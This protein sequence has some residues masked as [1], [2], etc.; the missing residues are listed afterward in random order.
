[1]FG[2]QNILR[3]ST[4]ADRQLFMN[5]VSSM[6]KLDFPFPEG[7]RLL[8]EEIQSSRFKKVIERTADDIESGVTVSEAF[9]KHPRYF[10]A[11]FISAL[12]TGEKSELSDILAKYELSQLRIA[13]IMGQWWILLL[14]PIILM[15]FWAILTV[16]AINK[17]LPVFS[18]NLSKLPLTSRFIIF[19]GNNWFYFLGGLIILLLF[20]FFIIKKY[21]TITAI[22]PFFWRWTRFWQLAHFA[23]YMEVLLKSGI[24][25][26]AALRIASQ[27]APF[28]S[29]RKAIESIAK[30][31]EKGEKIEESFRE[32]NTFPEIANF[33]ISVG[34]E[35]G[36][37]PEAFREMS[38]YF[39][40]R[41][42]NSNERV[43]RIA[44]P[45]LI[46]G[47]G[48]IF[49]LTLLSIYLPFFKMVGELGK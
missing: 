14:Y 48:C 41:L 35:L 3:S 15:C 13:D 8:A 12:K 40:T 29:F 22:C 44:E 37:L 32:S 27:D 46:I 5:H 6:V 47:I 34:E 28:R 30:N 42:R 7:L 23:S 43:I 38:A 24:N 1:M 33:F 45:L 19:F 9:S 20:I 2:I 36:T 11:A 17:F 16:F 4:N 18:K 39:E 31:I 21:P 26:G 49:A 10:N 25:L